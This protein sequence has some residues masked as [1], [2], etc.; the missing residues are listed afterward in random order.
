[1]T[2]DFDPTLAALWRKDLQV[3]QYRLKGTFPLGLEEG[4]K[5]IPWIQIIKALVAVLLSVPEILA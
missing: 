4:G 5:R 3:N 2:Q 1:M